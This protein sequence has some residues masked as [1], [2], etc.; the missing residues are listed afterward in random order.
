MT[1]LPKSL[2]TETDSFVRGMILA[3]HILS[4]YFPLSSRPP[5]TAENN[6]GS[7]QPAAVSTDQSITGKSCRDENPLP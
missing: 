2:A 6:G 7:T 3:D 5:L 1:A 4:N